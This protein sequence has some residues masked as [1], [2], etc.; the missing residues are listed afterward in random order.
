LKCTHDSG[1]V[2]V[3]NGESIYGADSIKRQLDKRLKRNYYYGNREWP[4]KDIKPQ[5]IAEKYLSAS[6]GKPLL[7][8]KF[9][10]FNGEVKALFVDTG[11]IDSNGKTASSYYRNVYDRNFNLLPVL[12][13]RTNS[14]EP[15]SKPENYDEM[16]CIAEQLSVGFPHLRV[17]MYNI[18]GQIKIG[19]LT[20]YHGSG[21]S[22]YFDPPEWNEKFGNWID[23]SL[24][25]NDKP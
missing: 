3:C 13:T 21:M 2:I 24:A 11:V 14:P 20:L 6:N 19:E 8:Y 17:D 12:E 10:C 1:S 9:M 16:L 22:N 5:I 4:Y 7:D 23:L 25:Y 15:I 18:D